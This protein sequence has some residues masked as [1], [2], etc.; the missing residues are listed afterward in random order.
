MATS[1]FR[2][3]PAGSVTLS[4]AECLR[5]L[6]SHRFGRVVVMSRAGQALIRPVNYIFDDTTQAVFFRSAPGSKLYALRHATEATFEI[7][8]IEDEAA[9]TGWS[10]IIHGVTSEVRGG[11]ERARLTRL[12]LDS[13]AP[14]HEHGWIRIRAWTVS[15]RRVTG[16]G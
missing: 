1:R 7:D 13:W 2:R 6:A 16:A 4:R 5:L 14:G 12:G 3:S 9:R 8:G 10:V 11:N 15:G